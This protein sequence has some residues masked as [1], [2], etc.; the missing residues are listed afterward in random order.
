MKKIAI[1]AALALG[2]GAL[3]LATSESASAYGRTRVVVAP[4]GYDYAYGYSWHVRPKV[5]NAAR[6]VACFKKVFPQRLYGAGA[7]F[8]VDNCY[9]GDPRW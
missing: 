1:A 5:F 2:L 7:F 9:I 3:G 4:I 6:Y 8:A